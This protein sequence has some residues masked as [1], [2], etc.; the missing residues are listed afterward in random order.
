M[1]AAE[2]LRTL[3]LE[4]YATA[5]R[6]NDIDAD[7]LPTLSADDL[8]ELGVASLGHRKRLLQAIA[9][10]RPAPAAAPYAISGVEPR[11]EP[12]AERR[13]VTIM[14]CDLV[15]STAMSVRFDPEDLRR[16]IGAYHR[17]CAE[18]ITRAGGFVAKY[19]GDG[20]LAYF[21]YPQ[22]HEDDAQQA[23]RAGLALAEGVGELR[24]LERLRVRIGIATGLVVVGDLIG[25]GSAQEQAI[26]GETPNLAARLQAL[27]EPNAIVIAESTRGQIG[28]VFELSDLGAQSLKGF[29]EPQRAWRVL[30]ENR[31][32]GRFEALRSGATPL[33]GREQELDQLLRRWEQARADRGRVVLISGEPGVGKSRLAEA[34]AERIA[35]EPHVRLRYFCSPHQQDSAFHPVIA[36]LERSCGF[37]RDDAP[38]AKLAKLEA[39]LARSNATEEAVALIAMQL[40]IPAGERDRLAEMSPQKR[41][42]NTLA[43]LVAQLSGLAAHQPAL[44]VYE[45]VHWLDPSSRELLDRIVERVERLPALLLITYRPEFQP[46]WT[47]QPHVTMQALAR[48]DRRGTA[49]MVENIAG[50][51]ALPTEIVQEIAERTDGVPLFIEELTK[52][53]LESG[54]QGA[55]ALSSVPHWVL[56]VPATLHA[57][58]LARLDRLGA[59]AKDV[60]QKG[61]VIGREFG[62]ELLTSIADLP[63]QQLRVA[64]ERLTSSGLLLERNAP[65]QSSYIFKHALVQDAAYSTL[66]RSRRQQLHARI[67]A[68][69]EDHFPEIALARPALLAHHCAEGALGEKAVVYRLKAGQQAIARSAMTEAIAQLRKGLDVLAGLPD[70]PWRRQQELDLLIALG[71]GLM[72]AK[73]HSA[74]DVGESIARARALA[75]QIDRPEYLVPLTIGQWVFHWARSEHKRALSLAEQL[76][77][78]GEARNDIAAQLQGRR[79]H[80]VTRCYLGEFIASRTLLERCFALSDPAHRAIGAGLSADPYAAMLSNLAVTLACLGHIDQ[81]RS[82]LNEALSEA[83]RLRHGST[84]A[85]VLVYASW[86]ELITCSPKLQGHAEELLALS[87][88]HGFSLWL[89]WATAFRGRSLTALGQAREG[90]ALLVQGLVAIRATGTITNAPLVLMWLAEAHAMLGQ[91]VAGWDCL[92]E[93]EQIIEATEERLAGAELHRLRGDLLNAAGDRSAAEP[94]YR[95]ALVVAERQSAKLLEMRAAIS[96]ARLWREQEKRAEARDLLAPVYAWFTE[97]FDAPDLVE[98][99]ALLRDLA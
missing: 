93:A 36:Q 47:G 69:L 61:S 37:E 42:E 52:T 10:L 63:E 59:A 26:V 86:T 35:A 18:L 72:W 9:A 94:N 58:L 76:E 27:A 60:A 82:R 40:S 98:A 57:S 80:G 29:A 67:V 79:A 4:Q 25:A 8:K 28:G 6:L 45:D 39:L 50:S 31:A 85:G 92:A 20:V 49:A 22:A 84:L 81:A 23:V 7:L 65:P 41:K 16:M 17:C 48:L 53:I 66:L 46:P 33:V 91:P 2:W 43:A 19:M 64:L 73:G 11:T 68:A 78:I 14:F 1:D 96:L 70:S 83:R 62:H 30:A 13:Q 87:T 5:F 12:E 15:G 74:A 99:K 97:G 34:L 24:T 32:L 3:G 38:Q 95:Q 77:Q 88:E 51:K 90:L 75:E 89:G 54:T 56:S 44:I 55:T 71:P 21:G